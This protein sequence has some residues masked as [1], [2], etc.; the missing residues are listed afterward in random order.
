MLTYDLAQ[1]GSLPRYEYLYRCIRDDIEDGT[2]AAGERL[3][4]KR[5]L[6][7]HLATSLVTV[8]SAYAQLAAEGYVEAR[9]RRGYYVR[10]VERVAP[11]PAVGLGA[12]A[13]READVDADQCQGPLVADFSRAD[14]HVETSAATLWER[15]LREALAR[16]PVEELFSTQPAQGTLRLRQAIATYLEGTRGI[17]VSPSCIVVGAG[18]QV[19]DAQIVKLLGRD[20][21]YAMEDP[22]Y[23]RLARL[24]EAEGVSLAFVGMDDGGVRLDE[25]RQS[26]ASVVHL[27]PSHQFPT[28]RVTSISRR[29]ELLGWAS[30]RAGRYV[31]ED[32]YDRDFRLAGRPIPPLKSVDA[33]GSVIYTDTF[34]KSLSPSLR[35]AFMVLPPSLVGPY[36]EKLECFSNTVSVVDQVVLARILES[37]AYERHVRRYRKRQRSLRDALVEALEGSSLGER[38]D[39]EEA[40]SGL[41]FVLSVETGLS[42]DEVASRALEGGVRLVPLSS[43]VHDRA[44]GGVGEGR[45][46]F[47]MQYGGL[48]AARIPDVVRVLESCFRP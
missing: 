3:P 28:G 23:T 27:M 10:H 16:E 13:S 4:S 41:H 5:S 15:A 6:A 2:L 24:F 42:E 36:R 31:I 34:T 46:R 43:F 7:E 39:V 20:R 25:L 38:A 18:T 32:D 1:R 33:Q 21:T 35:L 45:A 17:R 30:E 9:E 11:P 12:E 26:G 19:L 48:E 29:Y 37:G 22:G 44:H 14:A 47:V 40:D 8:E